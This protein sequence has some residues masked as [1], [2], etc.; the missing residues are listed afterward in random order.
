MGRMTLGRRVKRVRE[1]RGLTQV[2][3]AKRARVTQGFVSKVEAGV[4]RDP[5]VAVLQ[6]L[7]K[8]LGVPV[9]ALLG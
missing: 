3:L 2:A 6:R 7:A 8:A 4:Q 9:T 1:A 5:G